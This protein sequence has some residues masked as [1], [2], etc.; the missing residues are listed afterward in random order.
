[1]TKHKYRNILSPV[2]CAFVFRFA[3]KFTLKLTLTFAFTFAILATSFH[4]AQAAP[5]PATSSS[6]LMNR[7]IWSYNSD[8]GYSI[9][10]QNT[11]WTAQADF[12]NDE[13]V[14]HSQDSKS[15]GELKMRT[16]KL[17]QDTFDQY[18]KKSLR[19]YSLYGFEILGTK[20]FVQ[21]NRKALAVD[22]FHRKENIQIR[23]VLA[24]NK[25]TVV[26]FTC[27]D[28]VSSFNKTLSDCNRVMGSLHW[29]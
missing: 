19:E 20:S 21:D 22:L 13:V 27:R 5:L 2:I 7:Q 17:S 3:F 18:L 16:L 29:R 4:R 14:F 12:L 8:D 1:M 23:Q 6:E 9:S 15:L 28:Q 25:K 26:I 11:Q 24:E 10:R